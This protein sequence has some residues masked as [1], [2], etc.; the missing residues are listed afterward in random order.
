MKR[1]ISLILTAAMVMSF[2]CTGAFAESFIDV[3]GHWAEEAIERW[4]SN[5]VV[6]GKGDGIFDPDATLT[7]AE[8]AQI[9]VNLWT[10]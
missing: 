7:R 6:N 4:T 3:E 2:L 5:G 1:A 8:M 9:Y 10:C